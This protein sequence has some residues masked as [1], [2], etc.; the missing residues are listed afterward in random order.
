MFGRDELIDHLPYDPV[1]IDGRITNEELEFLAQIEQ[2]NK[3]WISEEPVRKKRARKIK[4]LLKINNIKAKMKL[5]KCGLGRYNL[6]II[7]NED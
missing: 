6:T 2:T 5:E 4:K 7:I 1:G 3:I